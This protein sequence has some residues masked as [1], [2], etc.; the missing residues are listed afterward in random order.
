MTS[1]ILIPSAA[2]LATLG[3]LGL[4]AR[5]PRPKLSNTRLRHDREVAA[6]QPLGG[7]A[8]IQ[9]FLGLEEI[10]DVTVRA[11]AETMEP[12]FIGIDREGG[13]P[14]HVER[15]KADQRCPAALQREMT[16]HLIGQRELVLDRVDIDAAGFN[17]TRHG[18]KDYFLNKGDRLRSK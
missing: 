17:A 12:L 13:C 11:A 15:A 3:L 6:R 8:N 16:A 9:P 18:G 4:E 7:R 1:W 14:L 5:L 2:A 10:E